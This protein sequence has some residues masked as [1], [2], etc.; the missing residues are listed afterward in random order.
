VRAALGNAP[1]RSGPAAQRPRQAGT[2][3]GERGRR[4]LQDGDDRFGV[5][6]KHGAGRGERHPPAGSVEQ[7]HAG[8]PF[9]GGQLL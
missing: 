3:R 7:R 2:G 6:G 5:P 1:T 4:L 8:L 9:Q